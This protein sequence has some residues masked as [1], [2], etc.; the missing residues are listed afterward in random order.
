MNP[1]GPDSRRRITTEGE[2]R[3]ARDEQSTAGSQH[4]PRDEQGH[5]LAV[6]TQEAP[7]GP[8]EKAMR[9]AN[10]ENNSLNWC[11]FHQRER[12]T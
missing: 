11:R 5:A 6:T 8:R 12:W 1:S 4:V 10:I 3:E 9:V 2:P 7:D